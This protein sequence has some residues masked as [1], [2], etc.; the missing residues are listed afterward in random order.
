MTYCVHQQKMSPKQPDLLRMSHS[1]WAS[2]HLGVHKLNYGK[3]DPAGKRPL[4]EKELQKDLKEHWKPILLSLPAAGAMI[5]K[6]CYIQSSKRK[7]KIRN[8]WSGESKL[9]SLSFWNSC[10]P[11]H[12]LK[13]SKQPKY[14]YHLCVSK[15]APASARSHIKTQECIKMNLMLTR[16]NPFCIIKQQCL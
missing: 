2:Q 14:W 15:S 5:K 16:Q 3:K 13:T 9:F 8:D 1:P 11:T 12:S 4:T 10:G 6:L 7:L